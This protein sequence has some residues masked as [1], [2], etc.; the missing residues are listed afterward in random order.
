M[1]DR[2]ARYI[3]RSAKAAARLIQS[4]LQ[5]LVAAVR[6]IAGLRLST[7]VGPG[8]ASGPARAF[9]PAPEPVPAIFPGR[10]VRVRLVR[11]ET[12]G[13]LRRDARLVKKTRLKGAARSLRARHFGLAKALILLA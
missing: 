7:F 3:S 11:Q 2:I 10:A 4:V 9:P 12:L 5:W 1:L 8:M 13:T 6:V